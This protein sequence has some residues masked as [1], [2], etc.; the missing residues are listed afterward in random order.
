MSVRYRECEVSELLF[1]RGGRLNLGGR[2]L[3][4]EVEM[5]DGV[6]GERE[7]ERRQ[8]WSSFGNLTLTRGTVRATEICRNTHG[9]AMRKQV[10]EHIAAGQK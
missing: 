10:G 1:E 8:R 4:E 7:E 9:C 2:K 6:E 3:R 5:E